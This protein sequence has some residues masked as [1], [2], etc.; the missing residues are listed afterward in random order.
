M[1]VGSHRRLSRLEV[2]EECWVLSTGVLFRWGKRLRLLSTSRLV[3]GLRCGRMKPAGR[4]TS[5]SWKAGVGAA[6]VRHSALAG[7][8]TTVVAVETPT[9]VGALS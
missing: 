8:G 7:G 9:V 2:V 4:F 6:G 1:Q 5:L 3:G